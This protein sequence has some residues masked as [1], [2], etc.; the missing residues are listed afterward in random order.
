MADVIMQ[1]LI[2]LIFQVSIDQIFGKK[3]NL[4]DNLVE[5]NINFLSLDVY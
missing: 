4:T 2:I 5:V 3:S 1:K